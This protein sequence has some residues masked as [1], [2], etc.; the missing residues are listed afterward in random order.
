MYICHTESDVSP[1][2]ER[3]WRQRYV[4]QPVVLNGRS[5]QQMFGRLQTIVEGLIKEVPCVELE[6]FKVHFA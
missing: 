2:A 3:Q 6:V 4:F 1:T 5:S